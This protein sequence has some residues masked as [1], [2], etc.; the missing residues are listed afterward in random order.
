MEIQ[1]NLFFYIIPK[2]SKFNFSILNLKIHQNYNRGND[3]LL[4]PY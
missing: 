1:I 4:H 2:L 3:N